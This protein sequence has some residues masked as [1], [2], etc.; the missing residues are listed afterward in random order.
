MGFKNTRFHTCFE[1]TRSLRRSCVSFR[2]WSHSSGREAPLGNNGRG[3]SALCSTAPN[4]A[5]IDSHRSADTALVCPLHEAQAP[6]TRHS[7]SR[8]V[9]DAFISTLCF[10]SLLISNTH[11]VSVCVCVRVCVRV[12]ESHAGL[13][14]TTI[15]IKAKLKHTQN[16]QRT[17][18][19]ST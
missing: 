5:F 4:N 17:V 13:P 10:S 8:Q 1:R 19:E 15:K 6:D 12:P 3:T 7:R 2:E 11:T 14:A 9:S 18:P 16:I